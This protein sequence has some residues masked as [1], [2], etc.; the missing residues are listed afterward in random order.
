MLAVVH[1]S[2]TDLIAV[3]GILLVFCCLAGAAYLAYCATRS[4]R[5]CCS[6][7][8]SSR[9]SSCSEPVRYRVIVRGRASPR[10]VTWL[11]EAIGLLRV[12]P[13]GWRATLTIE[14]EEPPEGVEDS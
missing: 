5:S 1:H 9:P 12:L 10:F 7:S 8:P 6:S 2:T 11:E 4:G 14:R 3:L 13:E